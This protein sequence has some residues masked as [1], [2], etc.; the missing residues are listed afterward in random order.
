MW[1][2][3]GLCVCGAVPLIAYI[4]GPSQYIHTWRPVSQYVPTAVN[5]ESP[6]TDEAAPDQSQ[7]SP[8]SVHR[9]MVVEAEHGSDNAVRDGTLV[10]LLID[11]MVPL[12][13]IEA[14]YSAFT[15]IARVLLGIVPRCD[16]YL[17]IWPN[18]FK[19]YNLIMPNFGNA[20]FTQL[21]L[22]PGYSDGTSLQSLGMYVVSRAAEC[23]YCSAHTCSFALR[24]GV[25]PEVLAAGYS[26]ASTKAVLSPPERATVAVARSLGRVPCELT[27]EERFALRSIAGDAVAEVA[28]FAMCG[29]GYLNKVMDSIGVELEEEPY[30]ETRE[31]LGSDAADTRAGTLLSDARAKGALM[32]PPDSLCHKLRLLPLGPRAQ[33]AEAQY[34]KGVP[35]TWPAVGD[36]LEARLGY[37][38]PL[39]AALNST[40]LGKRVNKILATVIIDNYDEGEACPRENAAPAEPARE[41]LSMSLASA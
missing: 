12:P 18:A 6:P 32:P 3:C 26:G 17:E 11:A 37:S 9:L 22:G 16:S 21:G 25:R 4:E 41:P 10:P 31:L 2:V 35:N 15:D 19:S 5:E 29:M 24:R 34:T 1:L 36:H 13:T 40:Y 14:E 20:P 7:T 28:V 27:D 8:T 33:W 38:F 39:L 23:P 30:L